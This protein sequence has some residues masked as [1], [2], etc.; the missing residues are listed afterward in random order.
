MESILF[1]EVMQS[2]SD[3]DKLIEKQKSSI[4]G[5]ANGKVNQE[6]CDW[7]RIDGVSAA[8][9]D[10]ATAAAAFP[11]LSSQFNTKANSQLLL[12]IYVGY[13]IIISVMM[14]KERRTRSRQ[15]SGVSTDKR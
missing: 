7:A 8:G 5:R 4:D 12:A 3:N 15:A 10:A 2:D 13:I 9:A 1:I 11:C 14:I 6:G